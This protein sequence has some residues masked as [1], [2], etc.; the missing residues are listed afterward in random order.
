MVTVHKTGRPAKIPGERGTKEKIYDSAIDLFAERGFDDVSIRD[1][2]AAVGIKESSIYKHYAS[3]DEI[4][5]KILEYP[6]A[7]TE[8]IGPHDTGTE[9][10]IVSIGLE[11]FMAMGGDL[12]TAWAEDPRM[13]KILRITFVELYHNEQ[14]KVFYSMFIDI[15][16]SFWTSIFAIM[17][18][19]K[20]IKPSDP[21]MLAMEY[22]SFYEKMFMD[23]FILR[24]GNTSSS[25]RQ[26]YRDLIDKHT[27]FMVNSIKP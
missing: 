8:N 22:I 18:K 1:I 14:V 2:A 7:R 27:T 12:I 25:F 19:H 10:L 13:V 6:M 9:E 3:K 21:N 20:L 26:E 11:A 23:Y 16:Y 5:E 24:Y 15:T 17:M 4:L